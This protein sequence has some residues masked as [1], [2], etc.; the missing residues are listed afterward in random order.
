MAQNLLIGLL[1]MIIVVI[2]AGFTAVLF[3][4]IGKYSMIGD[5]SKRMFSIFTMICIAIIVITP[6]LILI[7]K[8][9]S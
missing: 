3:Y 6:I 5:A 7:N 1:Y 4:H 9:L 2:Y 8:I